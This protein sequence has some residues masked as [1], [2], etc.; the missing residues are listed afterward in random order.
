[1]FHLIDCDLEV[2]EVTGE[3]F[4]AAGF[5]VQTFNSPTAYLAHMRSPD[6][7][8]P[9]AIITCYKMPHMN[10]YELISEV[11]KTYPLQKSAIISG[12]PKF[13]ITTDMAHLVCR[14]IAKPYVLSDL[15]NTLKILELCD[16]T[17]G[18]DNANSFAARCKFG[19]QHACPLYAASAT[20]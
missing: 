16:A 1:M 7:E 10:G 17:C 12:S 5:Q 9:M 2:L 6:F 11:R 3:L 13:D 19:I 14:Y 20:A 8:Q 4:D 15:L 18:T